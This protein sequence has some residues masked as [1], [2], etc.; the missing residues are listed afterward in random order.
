MPDNIASAGRLFFPLVDVLRAIGALLVVYSHLVGN[1]LDA[2]GRS[3]PIDSF[4]DAVVIVPL[5]IEI[6]LGWLGVALFFFVSGFVVTHAA[7]DERP[8]TYLVRRLLRVYPPLIFTVLVVLVL[9]MAGVA[10]PGLE[11]PLTPGDVL[12]NMSLAN[13]LLPLQ[14]VMVAVGWTLV[15]EMAFYLGMFVLH[16]LLRRMAWLVPPA[17]LIGS[18]IFVAASPWLGEVGIRAAA[19]VALVPVL[20][21]GQ[22]TYLAYRRLAPVWLAALY[23]VGAWLVLLF[24]VDRTSPLFRDP[25]HSFL[26]NT[27][28]GFGIFLAAVLLEGRLR[29]P[30]VMAVTARRSYS[31]YLLHVP[32]GYPILTAL[33]EYARFPYAPSLVIAVLAVATATELSYRFIERPTIQLARLLTRSRRVEEPSTL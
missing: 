19:Y 16:A 13:F 30:R 32:V 10:I 29:A 27:V 20:V 5:H 3:W 1:F 18:A 33:V 14:P 31:L 12:A 4:V 15:I 24:G 9:A 23:G 26:A 22:A 17:L 25:A 28:V 2:H 8:G 7:R 21:I 6:N 11:G